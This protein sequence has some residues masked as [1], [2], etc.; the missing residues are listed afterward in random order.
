MK[1]AIFGVIV[2]YLQMACSTEQPSFS[3]SRT[4]SG[5][6]KS[7]DANAYGGEGGGGEIVAGSADN[8]GGRTEGGGA[9]DGDN[10]NTATDS[11]GGGADSGGV[12]DAGGTDAG[13]TD[14]GGMEAGEVGDA[15]GMTAAMVMKKSHLQNK[16]L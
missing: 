1:P 2:L 16:S 7:G 15:M 6:P 8:D 13:G 10:G 9:A 14:A 11:G 3:E 12:D 4:S 5:S